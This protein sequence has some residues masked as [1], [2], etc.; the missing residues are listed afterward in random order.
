MTLFHV[1]WLRSCEWIRRMERVRS[2]QFSNPGLKRAAWVTMRE[3][4]MRLSSVPGSVVDLG[5]REELPEST[6]EDKTL[7]VERASRV[8]GKEHSSASTLGGTV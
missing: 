8:Q 4:R 7:G 6:T 3:E 5:L 2:R 1:V